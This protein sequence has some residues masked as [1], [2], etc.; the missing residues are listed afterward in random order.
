M[1]EQ[2]ATATVENAVVIQ[3]VTHRYGQVQALDAVSL[4]IPKGVTVGLIGPDGVGK[5]TLLS[6]IAGIKVIQTGVYTS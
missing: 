1:S 4:T 6:L 2:Q 3:A 5:S